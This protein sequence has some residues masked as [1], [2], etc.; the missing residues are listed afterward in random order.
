[1]KHLE[2]VCPTLVFFP[3][4]CFLCHKYTIHSVQY[5][6]ESTKT[7]EESIL[8]Y[9]IAHNR[10]QSSSSSLFLVDSANQDGAGYVLTSA[11]LSGTAAP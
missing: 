1:M 4:Q 10:T 2:Y 7:Q 6:I 3:P 8:L 5:S 11:V 9:T